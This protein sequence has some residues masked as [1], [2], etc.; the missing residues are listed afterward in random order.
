MSNVR[1]VATYEEV[2]VIRDPD[3]LIAV[4]SKKKDSD[5]FS[6]AILKEFD[7]EER[8]V[9]SSFLNRRHVPAIK[10][11][12]TKVEEYLDLEADRRGGTPARAAT[13]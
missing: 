9:R 5:Y 8:R 1:A 13:S 3:G 10:R 11:L 2:A 4:I 6:F 12:L 7:R